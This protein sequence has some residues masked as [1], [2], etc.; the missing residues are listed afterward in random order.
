MAFE[1]A[2]ILVGAALGF[3]SALSLKWWA[4][5]RDLWL[6]RVDNFCEAVDAAADV[7]SEYWLESRVDADAALSRSLDLKEA[8]IIG[9]QTRLDGLYASLEFDNP[10]LEQRLSEL[11]DALTGG[12]FNVAN[13]DADGERVRLV[14]TH[15]SDLIVECRWAAYDAMGLWAFMK[16]LGHKI[17]YMPA[18]RRRL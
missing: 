18:R 10:I 5:R 14:Q 15:A 16:R 7:A 11:R 9:L 8:K 12:N 1:P 4:Y 13:R 3:A 2:Q 6:S 17:V